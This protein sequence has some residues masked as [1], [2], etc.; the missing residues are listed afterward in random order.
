MR[1]LLA[2]G[3]LA[4][5]TPVAGFVASTLGVVGFINFSWFAVPLYYI[6]L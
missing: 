2:F 5:G 6:P 3:T 4:L 1:K